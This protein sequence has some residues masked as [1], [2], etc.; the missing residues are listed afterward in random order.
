MPRLRTRIIP[1]PGGSITD[2]SAPT[3]PAQGSPSPA[4]TTS[5]SVTYTHVGAPAGTTYALTVTNQADF[6]S[7]TPSSGSGLGPYVIPTSN[8]LEAVHYLTAT[9]PDGQVARSVPRVIQVSAAPAL[10]WEVPSA[11]AVS[12]GTTSATVT[13]AT[14]TGGT[15]P[16]SYGAASVVYDSQAASTTALLSTSGAGA[17]STT[18]SGLVNGQTVILSRTVTDAAGESVTVQGVATVAASSAT[19]TPGTAPASQSLAA[20]STSATIG[21]W[22]APSGGTGPYTYAVTELN[23]TGTTIGG[24]GLGP[25]TVSGLSDGVTYAFLLTITDSLSA[26]GY[27]VVT[28]AVARSASVGTWEVVD[29]VDFTDANWTALSST[30]ATASTTAWQHVLYAA[31]G[32]TPRAYVYNNVA[33]GRTLSLSPSG[34]GL[35]LVNSAITVQPTIGVWPAGWNA[36]RGG[37]RRDAWM[38]EAIFGGEEPSGVGAF[39]HHCNLNTNTTTAVSTPGTGARVINTSGNMSIRAA[40][41]ITSFADQAIQTLTAGATRAY[42]C[43]VQVTI[44]DSRRHDVHI[45]PGATDFGDPQ[46]GQRVRVQATSTAMTAP[47]ADVTTS[48]SWFA[49]SISGR[50]KCWLYHDGSATSGSHVR[51]IKLRLLRKIDGSL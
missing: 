8:G 10:S 51:L 42:T 19:V 44:A 49:T 46:T 25:W 5:V 23:G 7:I 43:G 17:G 27:S 39:G 47:G 4:G 48:A 14:P 40:S 35:T 3:P 18:V 29:S 24:S 9:G 11:A 36:M 31:D 1:R 28:I 30:D 16:Y 26:K 41:Y 32:V 13:W 33:D 21:T 37:S 2:L 50:A 15:T 22:G 6:S 34:Q 38:M 12:A 20:G 45:R